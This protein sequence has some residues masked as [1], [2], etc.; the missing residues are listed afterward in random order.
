MS[1]RSL[2]YDRQQRQDDG[3]RQT[4]EARHEHRHRRP[5]VEKRFK[6]WWLVQRSCFRFSH[7]F[8]MAD[9][10]AGAFGQYE[11]D[12]RCRLW[13]RADVTTE[14]PRERSSHPGQRTSRAE[15]ADLVSLPLIASRQH[16]VGP[17]EDQNGCNKG[18]CDKS[19]H[20]GNMPS[21]S[22]PFQVQKHYTGTPAAIMVVSGLLFA[23]K[24]YPINLKPHSGDD[25]RW[26]GPGRSVSV[27]R[28]TNSRVMP[29]GPSKSRSFRLM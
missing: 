26:C 21:N 1:R 22:S 24:M 5:A 2:R 27:V 25:G 11:K 10:F 4:H 20:R 12:K 8:Y 3:N 6:F 16:E 9:Q 18:R 23:R 14:G 17:P 19:F 28:C 13:A 7:R 29:S 15:F